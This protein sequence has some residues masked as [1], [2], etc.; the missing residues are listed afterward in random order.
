MNPT[1]RLLLCGLACVPMTNA[2]ARERDWAGELAKL[3]AGIEGRLGIAVLDTGTGRALHHRRN[4]R[5]PMCSTSKLLACA[6]LLERVDRGA[7][8]I[9]RRIRFGRDDLVDYSPL[10]EP[11][12]GGAGMTLDELCRAAM[13]VSDNTAMNLILGAI[14]GPPAVTALARALGDDTTRLDRTE[15][16]LNEAVPGDPRDTTT[17]AAMAANLRKLALGTHLSE[18]SRRRLAGWLVAN[19]TGD[20]RLRAGLPKD[21]R[22]GDKTGSGVRGTTNDVAI[23]WPPVRPPLIAAVYLTETDAPPRKR[24]AVHAAIA[25]LAVEW[26]RTA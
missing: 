15:P 5:F 25:R 23:F 7:D 3:E 19:E 24:E 11:H 26:S 4:E 20:A 10:T 13:I 22:V 1:R 17:P 6:A 9:D 2:F 12:A 8:Q 14:G 18:A 16:T 21:W